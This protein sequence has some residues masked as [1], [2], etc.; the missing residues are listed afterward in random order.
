MSA[1]ASNRFE[2]LDALRG[3]A[4]FGVVWSNYGA[5][6]YWLMLPVAEKA[7]LPGAS[8]DGVLEWFHGVCIDGKFY[9][10][11]S[12]LFGIGF[13]LFLDKG[14]T[15]HW[16][17]LWRMVV[18]LGIGW[19]HMRYIWHGD[20]LLL[21][22]A[23]GLLLPLFRRVPDRALLWIAAMLILS[24]IAFDGA[25]VLTK[26]AFDPIPPALVHLL[27]TEYER[28]VPLIGDAPGAWARYVPN[29]GVEE[30]QSLLRAAW[31]WRIDHLFA[32]N[33]IPKVLG[34]FLLGLWVARKGVYR[35]PQAWRPLL[36]RTLRWGLIVGLPMNVLMYWASL[37]M[38]SL[39]DAEGL[40]NTTGYALGVVPLALAYAAGFTLLWM[41]PRTQ[42]RLA[43]L[44]PMGRMALTNYLGQSFIGVLLFAG[45]GLGLGAQLSA[46]G[47][48]AIAFTVFI[49]QLLLS[50]W[51]M[52]RFRYGPFEWLWRS[53]TYGKVM[54]MRR[55]YLHS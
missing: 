16:R 50:H 23:L 26:G 3:F 41:R 9:S 45:V 5:L 53:L 13:G 31:A 54:P 51:W 49:L 36:V 6:S 24:P 20:I 8:L 25:K 33:R 34:L 42:E 29:G 39:P 43:L 27:D 46:L 10:I 52:G 32:S 22:A 7:L 21:Y 30:W 35:D 44:V 12:L 47:Y 40:V 2:L 19:L 28:L 37:H 15:G 14:R 48:E 1:P 4:L 55:L 38:G 17:F 18:L 11:F